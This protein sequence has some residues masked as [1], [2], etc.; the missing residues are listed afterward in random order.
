MAATVTA[1]S[2]GSAGMALLSRATPSF[3]AVSNDNRINL[4]DTNSRKQKRSYVEKNHLNHVYHCSQWRQDTAS[5]KPSMG[6]FAVGCS[7][8]TVVL[9][10]FTRGVVTRSIDMAANQLPYISSVQFSNDGAN[11]YVCS[12]ESNY[13]FVYQV[14]DGELMRSIKVGKKGI[15]KMSINPRVE[16]LAV[17]K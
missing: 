11:L 15:S 10:D 9:W 7:D 5:G 4:W 3:V 2:S 13:V 1:Y 17:A 8:G 16:V 14:S 6:V 12:A